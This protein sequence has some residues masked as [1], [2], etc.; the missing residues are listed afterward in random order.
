M[1]ISSVIRVN[2][3]PTNTK[4]KIKSI[5]WI[6]LLLLILLPEYVVGYLNVLISHNEVQKLM[7]E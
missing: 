5:T 2:R 6:F 1:E 3:G 7:G 4:M